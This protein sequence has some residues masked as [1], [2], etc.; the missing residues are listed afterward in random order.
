MAFYQG[1]R[2]M[3]PA[4]AGTVV[5]VRNGPPDYATPVAISVRQDAHRDRPGYSGT[6]WPAAQV[7]PATAT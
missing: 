3:T 4:G 5:Y 1:D 6:V 2:V 7:T